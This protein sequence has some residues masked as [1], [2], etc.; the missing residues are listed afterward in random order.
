MFIVV[1]KSSQDGSNLCY[2]GVKGTLNRWFSL[3]CLMIFVFADGKC[4][5]CVK[6]GSHK[7]VFQEVKEMKW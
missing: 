4:L 2:L 7:Y 5:I 6:Y 1:G 3:F